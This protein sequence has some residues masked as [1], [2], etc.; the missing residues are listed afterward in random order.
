MY[1]DDVTSI[2]TS[3]Q[4][5]SKLFADDLKMYSRVESVNASFDLKTAVS[6]LQDWCHSWQMH[7]NISK[8]FVLHLGSNNPLITYYLNNNNIAAIDSTRD[9]GVEVD[10]ELS[11]DCHISKIVAQASSRVGALFRGFSTRNPELMRRAYIIYIRPVLEYASSVWSPHLLKHINALEKVQ[12]KFT[13]HI[14][15][16]HDLTYSER[17]AMLNLETLESRRL[18]ADLALYFKVTHNLTPWP[19]DLYFN[20]THHTRVTRQS[21]LR[22]DYFITN[23]ICHTNSFLNQFF[24]RCTNCWNSLSNIVVNSPSVNAFKFSLSKVDLSA[25]LKYQF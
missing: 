17:L 23:P 3:L 13:K 20:I 8:T 19:S 2:S 4:V 10:T 21:E 7:I 18:K 9:L 12:R 5:T 11:F 24:Q 16:L 6:H 15:A 1:I 14:P 25:F 22:P